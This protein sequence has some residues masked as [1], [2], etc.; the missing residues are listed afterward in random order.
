MGQRSNSETLAAIIVAFW[1]EPTWSQAA[2]AREAGVS[3]RTVRTHLEELT[4]A[5]WQIERQDDHPHVYWSVPK[6][7]F[8]A[9]VLLEPADV[10]AL[11]HVVLRI[12]HGAERERLLKVVK[13]HA[14]KIVAEA[15]DRVVP[16]KS[17]EVEELLLPT[18]LDAVA[19]RFT[20][21]LRYFTAS[22][23]VLTTRVVSVQRVLV[24]PPTRFVAWCHTQAALRWFRLDYASTVTKDVATFHDVDDAEVDAMVSASV[25]GFHGR[26]L[27][28]VAFFVR[29]PEAR[30]VAS[31]LPDGLV[32][33]SVDGGLLVEAET[34][35][36]LPIARFVVGLGG[37]AECRSPELR[38]L[39]R[40]LAEGALGVA[41]ADET[42]AGTA[43]EGSAV[44]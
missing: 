3:T 39:V 10:A 18:V 21:K 31:N 24:G 25:D 14:P 40:E 4:R 26:D 33:S 11:V 35:G 30:W 43:Q 1:R 13:G 8:P 37:A 19:E 38:S 9:G 42:S 36:L 17:S 41:N 20:L 27:T 6:G 5:G 7:W 32:G 22:R 16:P 12:P 28:R 29:E 44:Q 2:L 23:G 34:A 15:L